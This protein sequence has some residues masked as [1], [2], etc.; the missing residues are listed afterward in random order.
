VPATTSTTE[1]A[2]KLVIYTNKADDYRLIV[3]ESWTE[4]SG[5]EGGA[6]L[7]PGVTRFGY[8]SGGATQDDPAL[9]ISIGG[10]DGRVTLCRVRCVEVVAAN[11]D[12]LGDALDSTLRPLDDGI[13]L[14]DDIAVDE[15]A[16]R[17]ER[18]ERRNS[19][20]G[21]PATLHVYAFH[22]GR[23]VVLAFDWWNIRFDRLGNG[24]VLLSEIV[25]SFQFL[26]P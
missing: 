22:D 13:E 5:L 4:W 23:P 14:V 19:C 6:D 10:A 2:A 11:L 16:G 21:C 20:L 18:P 8:G 25:A 15:E 24:E 9:A 26:G 17:I 3:P 12:E 1:P 7:P